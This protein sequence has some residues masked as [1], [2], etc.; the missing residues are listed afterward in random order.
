MHI[1]AGSLSVTHDY[2]HAY[3]DASSKQIINLGIWDRIS[4]L[5][6]FQM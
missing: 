1:V 3:E 6:T 2:E 5:K 4:D